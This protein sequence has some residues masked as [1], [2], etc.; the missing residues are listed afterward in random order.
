M[1]GM[2]TVTQGIVGL[3]R[4]ISYFTSLAWTVSVPLAD[5]Q[6]YD[7]VVDDGNKLQKVQVKTSRAKEY[8]N[9]VVQLKAVRSNK[10]GN[11][12][13]LFDNTKVDL[14]YILCEDGSEFVIPALEIEAKTAISLGK[15]FSRYKL[16]S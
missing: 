11:N 12:I 15:K 8:N 7:L 13:K 16:E 2:T 3:G 6:D 9:F 10:T 1:N 4:A 14:L 5:N